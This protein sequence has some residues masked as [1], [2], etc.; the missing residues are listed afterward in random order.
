MRITSTCKWHLKLVRQPCVWRRREGRRRRIFFFAAESGSCPTAP[1]VMTKHQRT[2]EKRRHTLKTRRCTRPVII[3]TFESSSLTSHWFIPL[4]ASP[5]QS[6]SGSPTVSVLCYPPAI[7]DSPASVDVRHPLV[8]RQMSKIPLVNWVC[9]YCIHCRTK[10][11]G[12]SNTSIPTVFMHTVISVGNTL[13]LEVITS[14]NLGKNFTEWLREH[15]NATFSL[16]VPIPIL[17]F[18][19]LHWVRIHTSALLFSD[20]RS[21]CLN[22]HN[23]VIISCKLTWSQGLLCC[24][25]PSVRR[26]NWT[27][28]NECCSGKT[29][30][31]DDTDRETV[32]TVK[33]PLWLLTPSLNQVSMNLFVLDKRGNHNN[34][35]EY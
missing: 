35:R 34:T 16:L 11:R 28:L 26:L 9:N 19:V 20:L 12:Y 1:G 3:W 15:S 17:Q 24:F 30:F 5:F 21:I 25:L 4:S 7:R 23:I 32:F 27:E 2:W 6:S 8:D 10:W 33:W 14:S 31:S 13:V 22:T 29:S 18:R